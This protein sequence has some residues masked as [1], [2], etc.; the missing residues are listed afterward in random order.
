MIFPAKT[1]PKLF[2][3]IITSLFSVHCRAQSVGPVIEGTLPEDFL[4]DL[5]A[6]ISTALR[7]SPQMLGNE[8]QISQAEFSRTGTAAQRLPSLNTSASFAWSRITTDIPEP[9]GGFR[10]GQPKTNQDIAYGPYYGLTASQTLFTWYSVTNQLKIA[11]IGIKISQKNYAEAFVGLASSIRTQYL[12]LIFQK[13]SLRNQRFSLNQTARLLA[14]DEARLKSGAMAPAELIQPRAAYAAGRL[15]LARS[16]TLYNGSLRRLARIAGLDSIN[17]E[18]IPLEVPKLKASP[19]APAGLAALYQRDGVEMTFQGQVNALRLKEADLNYKITSTR[20]LPRL[21]LSVNASKYNS[22]TVTATTITQQAAFSTSAS[23]GGSWTIFD[24]FATR[25]AKLT[26]LSNKR[27]LLQ[28]QKNLAVQI[29]DQLESS[30]QLLSYTAQSLEM[31]EAARQGFVVNVE[32]V[33]EEFKRGGVTEDAVTTT[34][35]QLYAQDAAVVSARIELMS[36][37]CELVTLLGVDPVLNQIPARYV[38]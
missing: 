12:G 21:G 1:F 2:V 17:E 16:E 23:I 28:Q 19:E 26:A 18:A 20:L 30:V 6:I 14:L 10:P 22:Q 37:W 5:K 3:F 8:V 32:R 15:A 38:H 36:R 27:L 29:S 35:M 11:D 24:G 25:A 31:T 33:T 9:F 7:Q 13:V 34:M 4:P